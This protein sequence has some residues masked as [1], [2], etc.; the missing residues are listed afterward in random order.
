MAGGKH[1]FNHCENHDEPGIS[2]SVC[3]S[4]HE[5]SNAKHNSP[6][7]GT[8]PCNELVALEPFKEAFLF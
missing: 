8:S 2:M 6:G 5:P 3:E 4:M 1:S 7:T